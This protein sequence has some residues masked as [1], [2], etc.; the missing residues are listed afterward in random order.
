LVVTRESRDT[1]QVAIGVEAVLAEHDPR[2]TAR[3]GAGCV[4]RQSAPAKIS[5]GF[6][7]ATPEEPEQRTMGVDGQHFP[8]DAIGQP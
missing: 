7:V 6:H 5:H 8:L 3:C 2:E 1:L 4:N